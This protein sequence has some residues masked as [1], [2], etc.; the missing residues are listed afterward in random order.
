MLVSH[1][2]EEKSK[3]KIDISE[4]IYLL[5]LFSSLNLDSNILIR[6]QLYKNLWTNTGL[7]IK[8]LKNCITALFFMHFWG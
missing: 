7:F 1:F 6:L 3:F 2:Y 5:L 8:V 4:R